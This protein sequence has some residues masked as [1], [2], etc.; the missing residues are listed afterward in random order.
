MAIVTGM[1]LKGS[2]K[3]LGGTVIYQAM[4]QTRQRELASEVS[5]PRT[6]AQMNQRVKWSNLVNLYRANQSWMKYAFETKKQNQSEYNKWMSLNVTN[7]RIYLTKQ[8]ASVGACVVDSYVVTQGS[9]PSI[10]NTASSRGFWH[11]NIYLGDVDDFGGLSIGAFS[12]AVLTNNPGIREGDQLSLVRMSQQTNADTGVPYVIV[13]KYELL[14]NSSDTRLVYDF[15]PEEIVTPDIVGGSNVLAIAPAGRAGGFVW[16]LSR[17]IS[18]RTYVSSQTIVPVNNDALISQYSSDAAFRAAIDSYGS[19]EDAFLSTATANTAGTAP[20]PAAILSIQINEESFAVGSRVEVDEIAN[21][22]LIT[23]TFNQNVP[24]AQGSILL[25]T[26]KGLI[27][28]YITEVSGPVVSAE[29]DVSGA[30]AQ[31][32]VVYDIT[33]DSSFG[34]VRAQFAVRN[35][36]TQEGME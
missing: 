20:V 24:A 35:S 18:G 5:N 23:A 22:D 6:E 3:R 2:K 9:L 30:A 26:N 31:N 21:D 27:R 1:W 11:S 14:I 28:A 32:V 25:N 29:F 36:D 10:E 33:V 13:R 12:A 8:M 7:S 17:T 19:S 15:L 4:G 34:A 16:I